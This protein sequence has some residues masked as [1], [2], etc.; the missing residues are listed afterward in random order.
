MRLAAARPWS[1]SRRQWSNWGAH[2]EK[3][4]ET[5]KHVPPA[6]PEPLGP[7]T[8][9]QLT[10]VPLGT[11]KVSLAGA[12]NTTARIWCVARAIFVLWLAE[13]PCQL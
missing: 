7:E 6:K 3:S 2:N 4:R 12:V 13:M 1:G 5:K 9:A 10:L 11:Q 8:V